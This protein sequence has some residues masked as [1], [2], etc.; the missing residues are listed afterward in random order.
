[1]R[2]PPA[3]GDPRSVDGKTITIELELT[4]SGA[5]CLTG[6]ASDGTGSP[7]E[8]S[9]WLGLVSTIDALLHET[10]PTSRRNP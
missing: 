9:G 2:R 5:D 10:E 1:M 3:G 7:R 8:F 4:V 6:S